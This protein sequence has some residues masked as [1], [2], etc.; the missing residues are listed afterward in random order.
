[1]KGVNF[2]A[3][4]NWAPQMLWRRPELEPHTS[5]FGALM[6]LGMSNVDCDALGVSLDIMKHRSDIQLFDVESI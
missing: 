6:W 5:A 3:R 2:F 1:M 4:I